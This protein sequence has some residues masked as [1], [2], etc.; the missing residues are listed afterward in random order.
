MEKIC[1][2][3]KYSDKIP[4]FATSTKTFIKNQ[5]KKELGDSLEPE[6]KP[7]KEVISAQMVRRLAKNGITMSILENTYRH[8]KK[9]SIQVLLAEDDG[10][11]KVKITKK[12]E[13]AENLSK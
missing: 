5:F 3:F 12:P 1:D 13:V 4:L 6:L 2:V 8:G 9:K 7:L 11:G 10:E